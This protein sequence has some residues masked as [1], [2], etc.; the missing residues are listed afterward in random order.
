MQCKKKLDFLIF[1]ILRTPAGRTNFEAAFSLAFDVLDATSNIGP[2][3]HH[4]ILFLTDGAQTDG[5]K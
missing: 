2:K 5:E 4:S 1:F 3:C